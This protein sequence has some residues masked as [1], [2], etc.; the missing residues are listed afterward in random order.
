LIIDTYHI[1]DGDGVSGDI[2][3]FKRDHV[4]RKI[5]TTVAARNERHDSKMTC[6]VWELA[7]PEPR[8]HDLPGREEEDRLI[9][10]AVALPEHVHAVAFDEPLG[11]RVPG[12]GLLAGLVSRDGHRCSSPR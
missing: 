12:A 11:V 9:S 5:R 4:E 7:L 3:A 10:C 8:V 2:T 6:E 1:Q